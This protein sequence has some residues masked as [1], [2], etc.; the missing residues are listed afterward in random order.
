M[1]QEQINKPFSI[2]KRLVYDA[3]KEV[4]ANKGSA[5]IDSVS[6]EACEQ[7]T[8]TNLLIYCSFDK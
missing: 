2:S 5:D 6:T 1:K 7:S 3:W 4:R 8:G